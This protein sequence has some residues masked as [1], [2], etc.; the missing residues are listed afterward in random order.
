VCSS[1]IKFSRTLPRTSKGIDVSIGIASP[2][3][4]IALG[5]AVSLGRVAR[6]SRLREQ[7]VEAGMV[8]VVTTQ[9]VSDNGYHG[10][11]NLVLAHR[12]VLSWLAARSPARPSAAEAPNPKTLRR[13]PATSHWNTTLG[14]VG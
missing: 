10:V 14:R 6:S 7:R 11:G 3:P 5:D 1:S 9:Y 12:S 2:A 4:F 13:Q 8:V